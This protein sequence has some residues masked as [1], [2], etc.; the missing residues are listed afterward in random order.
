MKIKKTELITIKERAFCDCGGEYERMPDNPMHN[1]WP[2]TPARSYMCQKCATE[3]E[4]EDVYPR[5]VYEE[6]K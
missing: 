5:I 2:F 3:V 1:M 6:L 4:L